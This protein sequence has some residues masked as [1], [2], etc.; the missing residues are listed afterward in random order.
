MICTPLTRYTGATA[1]CSL[2][3]ST[4]HLIL[5]EHRGKLRALGALWLLGGELLRANL[6]LGVAGGIRVETQE[7][8]LVLER[9]LLLDAAALCPGLALCGAHDALNF[10]AVDQTANIS[11]LDQVAGQEE[12][13]LE[14]RGSRRAAVDVVEG[15]EGGRSPD[16]E[17]AKVTT[18]RELE[19]VEGVHRA[20]LDTS[21]V[22]EGAHEL[23]AVR[24]GVVD[25]ERTATLA[26]PSTTEFTLSGAQ[27]AGLFD[28]ADVG[29]STDR[30]EETESSGCAGNGGSGK[31]SAVDDEGYLGNGG[32]LVATGEEE[33]GNG[34]SSEGRAGSE[35]PRSNQYG[36]TQA[37]WSAPRTS[38]PG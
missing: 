11:L 14:S 34:R 3:R 33:S 30:L 16:D 15:L 31:D 20:R 28:L 26:V 7:D 29:S 19:Q 12:V 4:S 24:L 35:S 10:A 36:G 17:A 32:D 5:V 25:D 13:L 21:N 23:A 8:L 9:V 1:H 6:V 2:P 22:A 27:L 18:G 38:V 37:E